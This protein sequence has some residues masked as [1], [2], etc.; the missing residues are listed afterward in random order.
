VKTGSKTL[1]PVLAILAIGWPSVA[2]AVVP[3]SGTFIADQTCP[4]FQSKRR[5]T[6]PGSLMSQPGTSYAIF[7]AMLSNGAP[8]WLRVRTAATQ[9]PERWVEAR[10]GS[11]ENFQAET[12]GRDG[13]GRGGTGGD[14][15]CHTPDTFDSHVLAVSWQAAFC[16]IVGRERNK[17]ECRD[18]QAN[19]FDALYL[20]LHGLWPNKR[21]CGTGYAYC[22]E[23]RRKPADMCDYPAVD[24]DDGVRQRLEIM[25][26]SAH[27]GSCLQRHE[28][29][30]HGTCSGVD[31]DRYFSLSMSYLQQ[32]NCSSFVTGFLQANIGRTV[33]REEFDAAFDRAFGEGLHNRISLSCSGGLLVEMR[34]SLPKELAPDVPL[35]DLLAT[36]PGA[37]S[38]RCDDFLIDRPGF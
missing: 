36:A 38:D 31:A 8:E 14:G 15:S 10:C 5:G 26:P 9:S 37:P 21:G 1:W 18:Q 20:T 16:E 23:V 17:P 4:L 13:T 30:K 2:H 29:W 11:T 22:G 28:W 3:A 34:L 19:R 25:M 12:R 27:Y 7:E 33:T 24:L 35:R 6:N 32:L